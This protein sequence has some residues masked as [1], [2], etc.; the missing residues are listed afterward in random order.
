MYAEC[1]YI[2]TYIYKHIIYIHTF[3]GIYIYTFIFGNNIYIYT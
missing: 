3:Y 2:Y 1:I